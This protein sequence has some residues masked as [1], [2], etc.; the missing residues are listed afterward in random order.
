MLWYNQYTKVLLPVRDKLMGNLLGCVAMTIY[1]W[2]L[3]INY[4]GGQ[5]YADYEKVLICI[6]RQT[7]L[8]DLK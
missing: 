7:D 5:L 6:R 4:V 2:D 3:L 8:W 1:Q